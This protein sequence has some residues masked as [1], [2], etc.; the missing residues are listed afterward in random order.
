M[1]TLATELQDLIISWLFIR[2]LGAYDSAITWKKYRI[3]WIRFQKRIFDR[4]RPASSEWLKSR[5]IKVRHL[6]VDST[7]SAYEKHVDNLLKWC[8]L[9]IAHLHISYGACTKTMMHQ[10]FLN[11]PR[12]QSF[13]I[14]NNNEFDDELLVEMLCTYPN[15]TSLSL[16]LTRISGDALISALTTRPTSLQSLNIEICTL[17]SESHLISLAPLLPQLKRLVLKLLHPVSNGLD[18]LLKCCP[19]LESLEIATPEGLENSLF[20]IFAHLS[21]TLQSLSVA[22][23][24]DHTPL[25]SATIATVVVPPL[26]NL[27]SLTLT[28]LYLTTEQVSAILKA[29]FML[30][31]LAIHKCSA[32]SADALFSL[33]KQ[34]CDIYSLSMQ[35]FMD[36][37]AKHLQHITQHCPR[38]TRLCLS[39]CPLLDDNALLTV[40]PL[41][42]RLQL[43]QL[44]D[45]VTL[46]DSSI[47]GLVAQSPP[48]LGDVSIE[49]CEQLTAQAVYALAELPSLQ[50][51][52]SSIRMSPAEERELRAKCPLCTFTFL[53]TFSS[54]G[55][56]AGVS[57]TL[58]ELMMSRRQASS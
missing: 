17:I 47:Q 18:A 48:V 12:L 6:L 23:T 58:H 32:V 20:A 13:S 8:A 9:D 49:Y 50:R 38:I 35:G 26:Y 29:C 52:S 45:I 39:T 41:L 24:R 10:L 28:S 51:V 46:T 44:I 30:R 15:L 54:C 3:D 55:S 40:Y 11:L 43:L 4:I 22:T 2:D 25:P 19:H 33:E 56:V 1:W 21:S 31:S 27:H 57:Q 14:N 36:L 5:G 42:P 7:G 53:F 34:R 37:Q 16:A